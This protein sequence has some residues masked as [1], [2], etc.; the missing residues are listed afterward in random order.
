MLSHAE[1]EQTAMPAYLLD[2]PD[3]CAEIASVGYWGAGLALEVEFCSG[4]PITRTGV[5]LRP[6]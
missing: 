6:E 5:R 1:I 2:H 4:T 3:R